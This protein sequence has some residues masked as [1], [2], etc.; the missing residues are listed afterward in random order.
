MEEKI[1]QILRRFYRVEITIEQA[2]LEIKQLFDDELE[3]RH[4]DQIA[5]Q[6]RG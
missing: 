6:S 2:A 1:Y 3:D 5:D 4:L